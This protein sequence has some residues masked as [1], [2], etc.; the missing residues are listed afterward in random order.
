MH[1]IALAN[2]NIDNPLGFLDHV[3]VTS[4]GI[5]YKHTFAVVSSGQDPSY[6]VILG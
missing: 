3:I 1:V 5:E 2:G 4:G 6:E